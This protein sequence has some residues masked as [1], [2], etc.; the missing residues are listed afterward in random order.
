MPETPQRK[1]KLGTPL[2]KKIKKNSGSKSK[3]EKAP[4]SSPTEPLR[5][6]FKKSQVKKRILDSHLNK[7]HETSDSETPKTFVTVKR[8]WE[9]VPNYFPSSTKF[10]NYIPPGLNDQGTENWLTRVEN[11]KNEIKNKVAEI[12]GD[13]DNVI[14]V[15][16]SGRIRF[17][18]PCPEKRLFFFNSGYGKASSGET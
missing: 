1:S 13:K 9:G 7:D 15:P 5:R 14:L 4:S 8:N 3:K 10:D 17:C 11:C 12:F 6:K 2:T 16:Y 18:F